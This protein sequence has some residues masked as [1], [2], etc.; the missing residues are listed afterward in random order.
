LVRLA[1]DYNLAM[2]GEKLYYG[3][4]QH[5]EDFTLDELSHLLFA[6][7]IIDSDTMQLLETRAIILRHSPET[8][9]IDFDV[10]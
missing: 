3:V 6:Q 1:A 2:L 8:G 7:N 5:M 10:K 4:L 9:P